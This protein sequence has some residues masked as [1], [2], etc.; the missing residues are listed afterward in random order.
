[1]SDAVAVA[2]Y[3]PGVRA[4]APVDLL[5][6]AQGR[7]PVQQADAVEVHAGDGTRGVDAGHEEL[8]AED[9]IDARAAGGGQ[10]HI[11]GRHAA[12]VI[13]DDVEDGV[14]RR[15]ELLPPEE[16]GRDDDE[17]QHDEERRSDR[18]GEL[19]PK[20]ALHLHRRSPT[21]NHPPPPPRRAE[22]SRAPRAWR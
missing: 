1:M 16:R 15:V 12:V 21:S 7:V 9:V 2:F 14:G 5:G 11:A 13:E 8:R 19:C 4:G 22:T 3:A 17:G 18:R 6:K 20:P 10:A